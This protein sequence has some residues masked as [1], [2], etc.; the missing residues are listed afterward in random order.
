MMETSFA[1]LDVIVGENQSNADPD[2][3]DDELFLYRL[4]T[5]IWF[6]LHALTCFWMVWYV[7][8]AI[9]LVWWEKILAFFGM[10]VLSGTIGIV[11]A[12]ELMHQKNR[13]ERWLGDLLMATT[14]YSQFRSEHLLVHH[15][16]VGTPRDPV[17]ARFN[18]GFFHFYPRVLKESLLSAF[19]AEKARLARRNLP[20]TSP[21]NPFFRYW[22]LQAGMLA[23]AFLLGGW[24]GVGLFLMQAGVAKWIA[25][26]TSY[27]SAIFTSLPTLRLAGPTR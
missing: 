10:G 3:P 23:L 21:G 19:A 13:L 2:T 14:L 20:W 4:I 26:S 12:H 18:E 17:T 25:P 6:P 27:S 22:A 8:D 11:Y 7:P 16:Y 24:V 15:R 9:H 5:M 1:V